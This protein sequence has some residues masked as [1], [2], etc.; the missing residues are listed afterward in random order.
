M[1]LSSSCTETGW[2]TKDICLTGTAIVLTSKASL[3]SGHLRFGTGA[4]FPYDDAL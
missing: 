2:S 3:I 1:H 4:I